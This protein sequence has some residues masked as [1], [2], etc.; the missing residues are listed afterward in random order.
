MKKMLFALVFQLT[1]VSLVAADSEKVADVVLAGYRS[2]DKPV[3]LLLTRPGIEQTFHYTSQDGLRYQVI[4]KQENTYLNYEVSEIQ[5]DNTVLYIC[6]SNIHAGVL[7]KHMR[8]INVTCMNPYTKGASAGWAMR[9]TETSP[10]DTDAKS[11]G[12]KK[13]PRKD[14]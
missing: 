4:L 2:V 6:S 1:A 5:S 9:S 12:D 8:H 13:L 7:L 10:P 11:V 14:Q 3:D